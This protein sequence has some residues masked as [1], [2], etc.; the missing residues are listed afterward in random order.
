MLYYLLYHVLRELHPSF[1][2]LRVFGEVSFRAALAAITALIISL[3]FG[4]LMI[5]KLRILKFGQEIREEGMTTHRIKRGTPTMGGILI[6]TAVAGATLLWANLSNL[7]VWVV[8]FALLSHGAIGF[9]D[10]FLKIKKKHNMG[11]QGRYKLIGQFGS[12]V[13]IG[14]VLLFGAHYSTQLSVPFFKDFRPE[15][16]WVLYLAFMIIV[17]TG[18]SNAVN[19]TDGLDGLAIS[20]TFVVASALAGL[21]FVTG[22]TDAATYL[23]LTANPEAWEITI[24]CAA[25]AGASLGFLWFNAP[26]AEVFMGDVGSLAIGGAI[27]CIAILI[28]Q[29]L[30]L[31]VIGGIFVIEALSV[32]MQTTYYK[33]TKDP[34]TGIGKRIF[35]MSPIHHHFELLG[36]KESKIVFRFLILQFLFVLL[37]LAT[38]KLR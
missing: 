27:G 12:E 33:M 8:L 15:L 3:A 17:M 4:P 2:A 22:Y 9:V 10:D 7:Y 31:V 35:K 13:I 24:F 1:G 28:K 16:G 23:G 37:G 18:S 20:T 19:L 5:E 34:Q 38:L 26:P 14:L 6:I 32:I 30:L 21:T 11:L 25:L 29:E 36:W